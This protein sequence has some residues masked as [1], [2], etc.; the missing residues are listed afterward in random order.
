[1]PTSLS[2]VACGDSVVLVAHREPWVGDRGPSASE[3]FVYRTKTGQYGYRQI[4]ED[5]RGLLGVLMGVKG[6]RF[7]F[8]H[9]TQFDFPVIIE[10]ELQ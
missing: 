4:G 10:Y 6:N 5:E 8:K 2:H 3:L 9:S 7:F 1:M